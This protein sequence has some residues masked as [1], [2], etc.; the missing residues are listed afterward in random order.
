M[1]TI[2]TKIQKLKHLK[3]VTKDNKLKQALDVK[4]KTLES[5]NTVEKWN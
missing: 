2:E 4:I 3:S 1:E 5:S